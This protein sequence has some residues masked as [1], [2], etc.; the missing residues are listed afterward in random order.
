MVGLTLLDEIDDG[1]FAVDAALDILGELGVVNNEATEDDKLLNSLINTANE[2]NP[3][4]NEV[5]AILYFTGETPFEKEAGFVVTVE[6]DIEKAVF[7][8]VKSENERLTQK[9]LKQLLE[10][11]KEGDKVDHLIDMVY[12]SAL[13]NNQYNILVIMPEFYKIIESS[14]YEKVTK[15]VIIRL[16]NDFEK[17]T[18]TLT[19]ANLAQLAS[20]NG[21]V[22]AANYVHMKVFMKGSYVYEEYIDKYLASVKETYRQALIQIADHIDDDGYLTPEYRSQMDAL[23]LAID[24]Y[25]GLNP[26][27]L[28]PAYPGSSLVIDI[29]Y[30]ED[31][32]EATVLD[33]MNAYMWNKRLLKCAPNDEDKEENLERLRVLKSR[34]SDYFDNYGEIDIWREHDTYQSYMNGRI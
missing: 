15:E 27:D 21:Y 9:I 14:K 1:S 25:F 11:I 2:G 7:Y 33:N 34:L 19:Y 4:A 5:L 30:Y 13:K 6:P 12:E 28:T 16:V 8:V 18:H 26:K 23:E 22:D 20:K 29:Y 10:N 31:E 3:V 24:N 17:I 32:D